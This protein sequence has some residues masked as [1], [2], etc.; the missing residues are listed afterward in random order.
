MGLLSTAFKPATDLFGWT[1]GGARN[2]AP[3]TNVAA[4]A[5]GT[6][7]QLPGTQ[8]TFKG[9]ATGTP[10]N[11]PPVRPKYTQN[12]VSGLFN[13]EQQFTPGDSASGLATKLKPNTYDPAAGQNK[14]PP[15][16]PAAP[17]TSGG[18]SES[19]PGILEQW[20]NQRASGTDPAFEY[21]QQRGHEGINNEFAARGGYNSGAAVRRIGD[22]D[23]NLISQREGQLDALAGGASGEHQ[24]RLNS[25]FGT[26]LGLANGQAGLSGMYDTAAGNAMNSG[27]LQAIQLAMDRAGVDSKTAQG[28]LNALFGGAAIYAGM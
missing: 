10:Q 6:P 25:M 13:N 17:P 16:S 5:G 2:A 27:N 24:G 9:A 19:G 12:G 22:F 1:N 15:A 14:A 8:Y 26:E 3:N 28:I 18:G 21:M 7:G 23:A 4:A 11:K 20:F